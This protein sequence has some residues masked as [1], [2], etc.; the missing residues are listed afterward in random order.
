MKIESS[1]SKKRSEGTSL[2]EYQRFEKSIDVYS[3]HDQ[4]STK[5]GN[6]QMSLATFGNLQSDSVTSAH[7]QRYEQ[8]LKASKR[9]VNQSGCFSILS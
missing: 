9:D 4:K 7:F 2:E 5:K 3:N 8:L 6:N 1:E